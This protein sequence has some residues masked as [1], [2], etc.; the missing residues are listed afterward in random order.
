MRTSSTAARLASAGRKDASNAGVDA[1][2]SGGVSLMRAGYVAIG[3]AAVVAVVPA[4]FARASPRLDH[5][6]SA[7]TGIEAEERQTDQRPGSNT[8][9]FVAVPIGRVCVGP[10]VVVG[11][12]TY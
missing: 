1:R 9:V 12:P 2:P 6:K 5:C 10:E 4:S 3:F 8:G 11:E 7:V